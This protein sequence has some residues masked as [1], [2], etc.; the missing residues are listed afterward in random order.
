ML[1]L[2]TGCDQESAPTTPL[3]SPQLAEA[4]SLMASSRCLACHAADAAVTQRVGH[5]PAPRLD[6][7]GSRMS[8]EGMR[9]FLRDPSGTKPHTGMPSMLHGLGAR[10]QE[11]IIDALVQYLQSLGGP[12]EG[13]TVDRLPVVIERGRELYETIGC[14]ACHAPAGMPHLAS[15][16]SVDALSELLM[17]PLHVRPSGRMPGMQLTSA[18][19][20]AIAC[21]LLRDQV[22]AG[23]EGPKSGLIATRYDIDRPIKPDT[24]SQF[25]PVDVTIATNVSF[26]GLDHPEDRFALRFTGMLDVPQDGVWTFEIVSDD[27]SWL[28]VDGA[29]V[30]DHGGLHS[31]VSRQGAVKLDAGEHEF[32]VLYFELSVDEDLSLQWAPPGGTLASIPDDAFS[33][34]MITFAVPAAEHFAVD[35]ELRRTGEAMFSKFGCAS[36]HVPGAPS[37]AKYLSSLSPTTGCLAETVATGLPDYGFD[38]ADR[39]LLRSLVA[40]QDVLATPRSSAESVV[41]AMTLLNCYACH[42]R[43]G[44][45]GV[46][47]RVNAMFVSTADLG[48]EGRL[49]P[50]LSGVGNKLTVESLHGVLMDG[51][52]LRPYMSIRM[53]EYGDAVANVAAL[54]TQADAIDGDELEP[55]FSIEAA[56]VG[57]TLIG[58]KGFKCIEC[59]S[60][61][62][63]ASMGEPG[64]D[65]A[66]VHERI[67][68]GWFRSLLLDPQAVNPGTRMPGYFSSEQALFPE[69][70]D[71]DPERQVDAIR[72]YLAL[73]ASM[74]LPS[75][76]VVDADEYLLQPVDEP[77]LI[78]VFMDDVSPRTIAVG[79]PERTHVA[80]DAQHA[81]LAIAWRGEF[82]NAR[83]TWHQ[84]AG[85]LESPEGEDVL[86]MP[87]GSAVAQLQSIE[88]PWPQANGRSAGVE[89]DEDRQPVFRSRQGDLV[90]EERV[91]P[92]LSAGGGRVRR[93]I[94]VESDHQVSGLWFRV[95]IAEDMLEVEDGQWDCDDMRIVAVGAVA[96]VV[97]DEHELLV[98]IRMK[99]S[100]D[101]TWSGTVDVEVLW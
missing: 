99:K 6:V 16:T 37:S 68:P 42:V 72:S 41:H 31:N 50:D 4:E 75:G 18:E 14:V 22:T 24:I 58:D 60:F 47:A 11:Q 1:V 20:D 91:Q 36:C 78:G 17:D 10:D 5:L 96:R 74:P 15:K 43:D 55:P 85:A 62:G 92:F 7:I 86:E 77:V 80:W 61:N 79:F 45:G 38:A 26:D 95:A 13:A 8:V 12:F 94:R 64:P 84:R 67:R 9:A 53:P 3:T 30:I 57:R 27:G 71:G 19:A 87:P 88:E 83:G 100:F 49:P 39:D 29:L 33:A 34:E 32:E 97:D 82:L 25:T 76:V 56:Q 54:F 93:L 81:R 23:S 69:L 51:D 44:S 28:F 101:G 73:G 89:R 90:I 21:F 70:L 66:E 98:P 48:D 52:R 2:V 46:D 63:H 35:E 40:N 65:L 59:H